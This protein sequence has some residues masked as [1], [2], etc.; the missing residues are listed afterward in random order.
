LINRKNQFKKLDCLEG[1][2]HSHLCY[3]ISHW[4]VP[5]DEP[6][7]SPI[8]NYPRLKATYA[9]LK[10]PYSYWDVQGRRNYGEIIHDQ[11]LFTDPWGIG[12]EQSPIFG[13]KLLAQAAGFVGLVCF[14]VW[15]YNPENRAFRVLLSLYSLSN[16]FTN[17]VL[18]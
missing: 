17:Y 2:W 16:P 7:S 9:N 6:S 8:G 15:V 12:S 3:Y 5:F 13:L 4:D 11:D 18:V 14:A 1:T 10:D